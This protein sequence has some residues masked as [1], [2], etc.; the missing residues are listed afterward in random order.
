MRN[1]RVAPHI[2]KQAASQFRRKPGEIII[3]G[4]RCMAVCND[5]LQDGA[6]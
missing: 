6:G 5:L 3:L 2:L 1:I 4:P